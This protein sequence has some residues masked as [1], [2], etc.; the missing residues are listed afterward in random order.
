[1]STL[2]GGVDDDG[3]GERT[4][5][6][7]GRADEPPGTDPAGTDLAG[8]DP[9]GIDP[10]VLL[11]EDRLLDALGRGEPAPAGDP[12]AGLF[13][14]WRA[15]L[16]ADPPETADETVLVRA[17]LIAERPSP[18]P[19][20]GVAAGQFRRHGSGVRLR[21]GVPG[22]RRRAEV[23]PAAR[24]SGRAAAVRRLVL[25]TAAAVVATALLGLG[26][27][28]AGPS[29]PLW[30]VA[31]AVYPDRSAVR[32]AEHTI[33]LARAAVAAQRYDDARRE[34]ARAD[35]QVAE[36]PDR[37][38]AGRLRGE[39]A[40]IRIGLPGA[41]QASE[42]PVGERSAPAR[43]DPATPAR[44]STPTPARTGGAA[45]APT[46]R[47]GPARSTPSPSAKQVLPLPVPVLPSLLPSGLPLL[48][49]GGCVLLCPRPPD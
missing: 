17:A 33:E 7:P 39:I 19:R 47:P 12:L 18:S 16:D 26:V 3:M 44:E 6:V 38:E 14:A 28:H 13:S 35:R 10:A 4:D 36:I 49:S 2:R 31:A 37:A 27:N 24:R 48:P 1:M 9:A 43:P 23:G 32:A 25:S 21:P 11:A 34:L 22:A 46:G 42:P 40:R 8:V 20:S 29:S 15:D 45:P 5:G 30:P 41:G